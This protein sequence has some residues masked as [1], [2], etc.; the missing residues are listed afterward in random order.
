MV[1]SV[2]TRGPAIVVG[3]VEVS[4]LISAVRYTDPDLQMPPDKALCQRKRSRHWNDGWRSEH[5]I[6]ATKRSVEDVQRGNP[7]D[8]SLPGE[9][10]GRFGRWH[11]GLQ[12]KLPLSQ[13]TDWPRSPI[14]CFV[15]AQLEASEL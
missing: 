6:L 13:A 2:V 7:S 1:R 9:T 4:L 5:R 11:G 8:P 14:D 3:D 12:D 15:L 10:T